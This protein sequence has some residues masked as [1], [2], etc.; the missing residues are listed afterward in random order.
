[1]FARLPALTNRRKANLFKEKQETMASQTGTV[2]SKETAYPIRVQKEHQHLK[3]RANSAVRG[4]AYAIYLAEGAPDGMDL[5]HWLRAES[6]MVTRVPEIRES[7]SWY[8]V[9]IP[10]Q[11]FAPEQIQVGVDENGVI[12]TADNP[13]PAGG[14][15]AEGGRPG[16]ESLFLVATWPSSVDPSTA[17][18]YIKGEDL[19]LTVKRASGLTTP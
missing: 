3:D 13:E 6:E 14:K 1:L 16:R 12:I 8:V 18:A 19:T 15:A 2:R 5:A 9:N 17:S 4:R 10:V 7:S 11:H